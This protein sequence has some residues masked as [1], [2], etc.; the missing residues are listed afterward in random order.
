MNAFNPSG[1]RHFLKNM[2][3]GD[4]RCNHTNW[5][6]DEFRWVFR[7]RTVFSIFKQSMN[8]LCLMLK[9][10]RKMFT[11]MYLDKQ[12][13]Q[14]FLYSQAKSPLH[15]SRSVSPRGLPPISA[16][17]STLQEQPQIPVKSCWPDCPLHWVPSEGSVS[18]LCLPS[19]L[20]SQDFFGPQAR[21]RQRGHSVSNVGIIW[22]VLVLA[23]HNSEEQ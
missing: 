14:L 4:P 23:K 13:Y 7:D 19:P 10:I 8:P 2:L 1:N 3:I 5:K 15:S 17:H 12:A 22:I 21:A 18:P 16:S 9:C 11:F 20:L 6:K